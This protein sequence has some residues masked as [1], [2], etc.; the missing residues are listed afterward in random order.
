MGLLISKQ[1]NENEM[2]LRNISFIAG[3]ILPDIWLSFIYR[4][5]F[6]K[7]S[8]AGINKM[9]RRLYDSRAGSG[10]LWFSY[11][12]GVVTHYICDFFCYSHTPAFKGG[13]NGHRR[14]EKKQTV[15]AGDMLPFFKRKCTNID[16][17][18]LIGMLNDYVSRHEQLLNQN[19]EMSYT[20]IPVAVLAAA[21]TAS[22]VYL[23]G[24]KEPV[25]NSY[26]M[27]ADCYA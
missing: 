5:H 12:L 27:E 4:P 25:E 8:A 2:P 24:C 10:G 11:R 16:Y 23:N 13:L 26:K 21:W 15:K 1:M 6:R 3:N 7:F 18:V 14:Y 22:V 9:L 19:P 20:D 17:D